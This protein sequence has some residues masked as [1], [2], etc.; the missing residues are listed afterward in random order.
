LNSGVSQFALVGGAPTADH[1]ETTGRRQTN[2][3]GQ[4]L[5]GGGRELL[6]SLLLCRRSAARRRACWPASVSARTRSLEPW[7][8]S[9]RKGEWPRI[10]RI[11][12]T[13]GAPGTNRPRELPEPSSGTESPLPIPRQRRSPSVFPT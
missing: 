12:P 6:Q 7:V 3:T 5:L 10:A 9:R 13:G 4:V 1:S 2:C 8:C 11:P